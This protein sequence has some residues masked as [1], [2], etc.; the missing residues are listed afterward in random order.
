MDLPGT[1][2]ALIVPAERTVVLEYMHSQQRPQP[3]EIMEVSVNS[4]EK[5]Q[6]L[7]YH[8]TDANS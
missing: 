2:N 6:K 7:V 5:G 8:T 1:Y 4:F 3:E